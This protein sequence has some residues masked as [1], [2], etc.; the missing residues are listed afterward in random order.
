MK[1][2][3]YLTFCL[4]VLME[5]NIG[6]II[7][8]ISE[9]VDKR[10]NARAKAYGLT[11][12]QCRVLIYLYA[13]SGGR[14]TQRDLEEYLGATHATV[15]GIIR[16]MRCHGL[17]TVMTDSSDRRA[18][19]IRLKDS[20]KYDMISAADTESRALTDFIT[21]GFTDKEKTDFFNYLQRV[22]HNV[23]RA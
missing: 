6:L 16:R 4:E 8:R 23:S 21:D 18:K 3:T 2:A 7:K 19:N 17:V 20:E 10:I 13:N 9:S 5:E 12:T 11:L 15:S 14:V 1:R 22:Y